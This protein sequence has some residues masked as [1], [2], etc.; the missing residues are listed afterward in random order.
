MTIATGDRLPAATFK[1]PTPEGFRDMTT[2]D[3]FAGRTVVLFGVPGAFT[4]TCSNNHLPGFH[5][6]HEAIKA[7]GVDTIAVVSVNDHHVMKAW[8]AH[9]G[10]ADALLF[11]ADGNGAF[12]RAIGLDLDMS[13]G[14]MGV[15]SKRF[16]MIV[17][18]GVV[19]RLAV[20]DTPGTAD[21]SGAEAILAAL[22]PVE[23]A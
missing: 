20:E 7:R 10:A 22:E 1:V 12:V 14:G 6:H 11:L 23:A 21:A 19:T 5:F 17:R 15:R 13:R 16:S 4:P 9:T 3:V 2:D 8:A 18:D